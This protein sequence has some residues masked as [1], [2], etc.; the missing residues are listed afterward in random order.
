MFNILLKRSSILLWLLASTVLGAMAG[1]MVILLCRNAALRWGKKLDV[2]RRPVINAVHKI[3]EGKW[4]VGLSGSFI[5]GHNLAAGSLLSCTLGG[6]S[7]VWPFAWL[8]FTALL[9]VFVLY[10]YPERF[11]FL[12]LVVIVFEFGAYI[13][14][15][16]GGV[17][18]GLSIF[19]S[20]STVTAFR[21][22]TLLFARGVV[23]FQLIQGYSEAFLFN[24]VF[25]VDG[26]PWPHGI[27]EGQ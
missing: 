24:K 20:G 11:N 7:V 14:A 10:R 27:G 19:G 8:F 12:S 16:V 15:A 4:G 6:L 3:I 17:S 13:V 23:P 26:I 21:D 5:F 18:I 9:T 25:V 22:W 1:G 2:Q